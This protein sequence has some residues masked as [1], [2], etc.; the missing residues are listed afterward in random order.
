MIVV[1]TYALHI[2]AQT[3]RRFGALRVGGATGRYAREQHAECL[4]I[5]REYRP[6][7]RLP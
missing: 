4:A 3:R 6:A 7:N 1:H 2:A 5:A